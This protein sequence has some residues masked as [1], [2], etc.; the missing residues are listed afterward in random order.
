MFEFE[1]WHIT[2]CY[3]LHLTSVEEHSD[4]Y[5][6]LDQKGDGRTHL[7]DKFGYWEF[8]HW[9]RSVTT[10]WQLDTELLSVCA[11]VVQ[12]YNH[13]ITLA[14]S[15]VTVQANECS[16]SDHTLLQSSLYSTYSDHVSHM[17]QQYKAGK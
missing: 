7:N 14:M 8:S 9:L 12:C 17:V 6:I 10:T 13:F 5:F 1:L 2:T 15:L 3:S 11:A 4:I 16:A